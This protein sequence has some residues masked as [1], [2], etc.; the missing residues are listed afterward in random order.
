[1]DALKKLQAKC[2][3]KIEKGDSEIF[4]DQ[5]LFEVLDLQKAAR[6]KIDHFG[7]SVHSFENPIVKEKFK[8]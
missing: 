4:N 6:K 3:Q 1:L 8:S 7:K 2:D 5:F